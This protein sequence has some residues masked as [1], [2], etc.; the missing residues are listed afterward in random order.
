MKK[1]IPWKLYKQII[2]NVP[3][4][5][6]DVAIVAKGSVLLV[7]RKDHPAKGEWWLPGGRAS[8]G[9]CNTLPPPAA[10][11]GPR[12]WSDEPQDRRQPA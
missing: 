5:C 1:F 9:S 4:A 8:L 6:V 2:G 3:I 11:V 10:A 7:R 12:A